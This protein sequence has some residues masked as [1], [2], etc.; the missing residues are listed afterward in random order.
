MSSLASPPHC[1]RLDP[2]AGPRSLAAILN[3]YRAH[4][5]DLYALRI[6]QS[7]LMRRLADC[8]QSIGPLDARLNA[9]DA[10]A[11]ASDAI[12]AA[13]EALSHNLHSLRLELRYAALSPPVLPDLI[14]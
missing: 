6:Q 9:S 10:Y 3:E 1:T 13:I 4:I 5:T 12:T 8:E 14:P 11:S 2:T 7:R